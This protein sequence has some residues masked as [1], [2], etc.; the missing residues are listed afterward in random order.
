M[1]NPLI[2]DFLIVVGRILEPCSCAAGSSLET[3]IVV[4]AEHGHHQVAALD[5]DLHVHSIRMPSRSSTRWPS[6][7]PHC[8]RTDR[9]QAAVSTILPSMCPR[10]ARSWAIR[11]RPVRERRRHAAGRIHRRGH[12][13]ILE[14]QPDATEI[15]VERVKFLRYGEVRGDYDQVVATLN[16]SDPTGN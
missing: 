11:A 8:L 4:A 15:Q 10:A 3:L 14:T 12:G 13:E 6:A 2:G 7:V 16:A 1:L 9:A 5:G